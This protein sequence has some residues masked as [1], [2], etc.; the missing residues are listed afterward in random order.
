MFFQSFLDIFTELYTEFFQK[1]SVHL[2]VLQIQ[3]QYFV[4]IYW[5]IQ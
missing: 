3:N 1:F 5:L 4:N 2:I